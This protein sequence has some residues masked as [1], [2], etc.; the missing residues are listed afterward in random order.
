MHINRSIHHAFICILLL[1]L[2]TAAVHVYTVS[3]HDPAR[4]S[5]TVFARDLPDCDSSLPCSSGNPSVRASF[6]EN[7]G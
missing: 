6:F 5:K 3:V 4:R 1:A 7:A 2:S